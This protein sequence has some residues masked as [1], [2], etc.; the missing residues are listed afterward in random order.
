[1][2]DLYCYG[3]GFALAAAKAGAAAVTAIDSSAPSWQGSPARASASA[4]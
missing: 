2:L 4:W 3:G 1:V